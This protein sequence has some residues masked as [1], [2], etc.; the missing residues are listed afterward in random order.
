MLTSLRNAWRNPRLPFRRHF[1]V[2]ALISLFAIAQLTWWSIFQF[3][4]GRRILSTQES[5]WTQQISIATEKRH[6]LGGDFDGWL[7]RAFSD[8]ESASGGAIRVSM[9][10]RQRL[11][12][13]AGSR[14]RMFISEGAF[15]GLLVLV[16][17]LY[18]FRT[19]REE[20]AIEHRQS[21]FLAATSHEL[22]TPIT[23]LRMYLDTLRERALPPEK[24]AEMLE[25]MSVDLDRLNDLIERLLQAQKVLTAD[26]DTACEHVDISEET[27]RAVKEMVHRIEFTGKFR[28]N[29]DTEYGRHAHADP[30]RWQLV[31]KNLVDNAVK[32]S[33]D[34]G[35]IDVYLARRE[36]WIEL[37]VVDQGRGFAPDEA[38]RLFERFYRSG[39]E[40]TRTTQGVGLGL[41]LVREI[42]HSMRGR[43]MARSEGVGRGSKFVVQI[44]LAA[45]IGNA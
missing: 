28:L 27:V 4:E 36:R 44:P 16:G 5:Y 35:M 38:S 20:I 12:E 34:G 25:V 45:E 23:S 21:V 15:F 29:I 33:P 8:L 30:R 19:L 1:V 31:V 9:S 17:V 41:Y 2:F 13:L 39:N 7:L 24:R 3:H 11:D 22:K 32:Y 18:M 10:A 43:V 26:S 42:V 6:E 40:D 37:S 14:M